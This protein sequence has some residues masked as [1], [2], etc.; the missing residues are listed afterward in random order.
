MYRDYEDDIF[1]VEWEIKDEAAAADLEYEQEENPFE[2]IFTFFH[3]AIEN[4]KKIP[5][6]ITL[7]DIYLN[8]RTYEFDLVI[9]PYE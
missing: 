4:I 3:P 6:L 5:F 1:T 7:E 8:E 9:T 2:M